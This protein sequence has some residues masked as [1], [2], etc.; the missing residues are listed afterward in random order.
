M[1][2]KLGLGR[3]PK[4]AEPALES[5]PTKPVKAKKTMPETT[6][7]VRSHSKAEQT[8]RKASSKDE[9]AAES[10]AEAA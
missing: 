10:V 3:K 4:D 5:E 7:T 6:K 9:K 1:A 8:R 2:L